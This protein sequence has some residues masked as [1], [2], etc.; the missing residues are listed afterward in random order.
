MS[1]VP[2]HQRLDSGGIVAAGVCL[3]HCALMPL[4][5]LAAPAIGLTVP[6]GEWL[7]L[8][9]VLTAV[10]IGIYA[11]FAGVTRHHQKLPA[12]IA[13]GG[14]LLLLTSLAEDQVGEWSE[15]LASVGAIILAY[16]HIRNMRA[17]CECCPC[18]TSN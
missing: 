8:P 12:A 11:M 17:A 15:Y 7:H 1:L 9:L 4:V 5:V 3:L 16:G 10:L 13:A 2:Y 18:S 14:V 6:D